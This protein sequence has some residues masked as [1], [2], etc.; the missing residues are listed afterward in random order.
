MDFFRLAWDEVLNPSEPLSSGGAWYLELVCEYLTLITV[1]SLLALDEREKAEQLLSPY[2]VPVNDIGTRIPEIRKLLLNMP[3]RCA[4]STLVTLVWP[5]WEWL[6]MPWW[7]VLFLSYD[8]ALAT[9]HSDDRRKILQSAFYQTLSGGLRLSNSK[10]RLTEYENNHRGEM[11]ARGLNAGVTGGGGHRTIL[12]DPNDPQ[13]VE[14]DTIRARTLKQFRDYTVTRKNSPQI[15][16]TVVVQQRTHTDDV[17]GWVID[18][19]NGYLHICLP[20]EAEVDEEIVFPLSGRK[21]FRKQGDCIDPGRFDKDAISEC[22][23]ESFIWAGRYQQRPAPIE[24]GMI[25][26]EWVRRYEVPP[27]NPQQIVLS[28]DSAAKAKELNDPWCWTV[29]ACDRELY[30]LLYCLIQRC[31][32]PEGKRLTQ[33]LLQ[34]WKPTHTLIEDKSTGQ[35]LIPELRED[36]NARRFNIIPILPCTDKL[37]RMAT[38]SGAFESGRVYLPN[39]AP[40][41]AEYESVIYTFPNSAI[42]DPVDS[43]SQFLKWRRTATLSVAPAQSRPY[44]GAAKVF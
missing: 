15:A 34:K 35:S 21:V 25:K 29:W 2:G 9:D 44:R 13:K 42:K 11:K 39:M 23:A 41:L 32:Y 40:W 37:T 17:S 4:K 3:P 26:R 43:T 31:E 6:V 36:P 8:Q 18:N 19:A 10:N 20:M 33:S 16:A 12:D 7:K 38:E 28:L 22:K 14:T 24:G 5:C 30:Y 1:T 27:A